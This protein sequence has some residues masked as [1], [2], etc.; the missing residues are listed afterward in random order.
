[1]RSIG[2]SSMPPRCSRWADGSYGSLHGPSADV[3]P[4]L[5]RGSRS[6]GRA[7]S[8]WAASMPR[9][10][11]S[12][13]CADLTRSPSA[14][15]ADRGT[16]GRAVERLVET[17]VAH[18]LEELLGALRE[19]PARHEDEAPPLHRVDDPDRLVD[20]HATH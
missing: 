11:A 18:P 10:N 16:Q 3:P 5:A 6:S 8:T 20:I 4:R 12:C 19:R 17:W 2:S 15:R 7:P 1:M 14:H 9:C 13:A